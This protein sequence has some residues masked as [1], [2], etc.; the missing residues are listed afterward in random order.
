[1]IVHVDLDKVFC[2]RILEQEGIIIE[3]KDHRL[4]IVNKMNQYPY[5]SI[6]FM[7]MV[8]NENRAC[9][10]TAFQINERFAL[11]AAHNLWDKENDKP[12]KLVRLFPSVSGILSIDKVHPN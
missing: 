1:M 7:Y 5:E 3:G 6:I 4:N 12:M 9:I 8:S 11:T 2:S 10:G